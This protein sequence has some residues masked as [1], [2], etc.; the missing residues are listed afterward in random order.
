MAKV[1]R[2]DGRRAGELRPVTI[3]P[4]FVPS[5]DGSCLIEIGNTRVICTASFCP[6]VPQWRAESGLGWV[7]AEYGMLPA[8]TGTRRPRPGLKAD[9]RSIEIQRIIGRVL[10]NVVRF[11]RLGPNT[12]VLDCDVLQAD[13]STR[14]ASITGSYVALALATGR[15]AKAD[16]C[17][18][19]VTAGQVA[20][21]SVGI[22]DGQTVLDLNYAEDSN[23]QV[24]MNVA[25]LRGDNLVEVQAS[26]ER[27]PFT[28]EQFQQM[29]ALA[30]RGIGRL[31]GIQRNA[32]RKG[33]KC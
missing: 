5:A 19:G 15:S 26:S 20:A 10:R 21:V 3:T 1:K 14:T 8:S 18:R 24:D 28:R 16:L 31:F 17:A 25:M 9:S 33:L 23:A 6:G 27:A 11:D 13:G 30:R 29:L 4:G 7:T 32:I 2:H 22:V 12:I